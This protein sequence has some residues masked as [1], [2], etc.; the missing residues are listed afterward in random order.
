MPILTLKGYVLVTYYDSCKCRSIKVGKDRLLIVNG[1][2][3]EKIGEIAHIYMYTNVIGHIDVDK[4]DYINAN[5]ST[6][7]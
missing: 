4:S 2:K 3:R 1:N 5:K 6:V 7:Y